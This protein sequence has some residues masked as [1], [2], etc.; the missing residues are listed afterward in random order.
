MPQLLI[1]LFSE[2]IPARMQS[3][4]SAA[5]RD[6]ICASLKDASL[7]FDTCASYSTPRRIVLVVDG[8][9]H[10]Q[11]DVKKETR[12]PRRDAPARALEGFLTANNLTREE[13][14]VRDAN[15]GEF[16]FATIEK[17]GRRTSDVVKEILPS[18]ISKFPWQKSMRWGKG[19]LRW[20]RPLKNIM[21]ILDGE[22]VQIE[23]ENEVSSIGQSWGHRFYSP[24]P[25]GVS[26]FD[27]YERSLNQARVILDAERR[28][29]IIIEGAEKLVS[30]LGCSIVSD[31]ALLSEVSGLVEWPVPMLGRIDP[32]F[33][34]LPDEVLMTS[35]KS[36]QKYFSVKKNDGGLAPYFVVVANIDPDDGGKAVVSGNERVLRARLS[37]AKFFWD[38]DRR[39]KLETSLPRLNEMIFHEKLGS[40]SHKVQRLEGLA[41]A[42]GP[43]L[44]ADAEKAKKAAQL[45]KA[46]LVS[47]MVGEFASLQGIMGRYYALAS[48]EHED[49]ARAIAEHYSPAG[50]NDACPNDRISLT[51]SISDKLD[52]LVGFFGVN[53]KPTG[54]RDPFALR[55]AALG[56]IRMVMENKLRLPLNEIFLMAR[57]QY[58]KPAADWEILAQFAKTNDDGTCKDLLS[59]FSD[60]LKVHLRSQGVRHDLIDAVFALK[61]EDDLFRIVSRVSALQE[62]LDT[63]D[64][65]NLLAGYRRATNIVE[66]EEKKDGVFFEGVIS[67]E[68]LVETSERRLAGAIEKAAKGVDQAL[69]TEDF[70]AAMAHMSALREPVDLFFDNVTVNTDKSDIRE[71][72]LRLLSNFRS[73][74]GRVA[75][76]E[77]I[78]G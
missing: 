26:N 39:Q 68:V 56:I 8:L 24:N 22:P 64:G 23:L 25:F 13:C 31:P 52:T 51:I 72:R 3:N 50:P 74:I 9:P 2:E 78:K 28:Q 60:R 4:G 59:F 15:K 1:E 49:V 17:K 71:N 54:S 65:K 53:E 42:L 33:M 11:T 35:M 57:E 67:P 75:S 18:V 55:R 70:S 21:C 7:S 34:D 6:L 29:K 76:F 62:F 38:Q 48:G 40:L 63:E 10:A 30:A 27:D 77:N 69:L 19:S 41:V 43:L 61:N 37:D 73:L 12:G 58:R 32:E 46:D 14:Q 66:I 45:C 5:L 47:G 20:V 16:W 36:H 44:D